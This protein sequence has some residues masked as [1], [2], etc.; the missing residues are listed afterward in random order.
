MEVTSDMSKSMNAEVVIIGGGGSGLVAAISALEKGVKNILILEKRSK[1]GGN[2]VFPSGILAADTP[3]Q[4]RLGM[5]ASKDEV[6]RK[7]M[8]YSHWRINGSL[9]RALIDKSAD[10]LQWL[11]SKGLRFTHIITHYPN[12]FPNTYITT[13]ETGAGQQMVNLLSQ[14]LQKSKAVRILCDTPARK[15]LV[16]KKGQVS[17]VLAETKDGTEIE[18]EAKSV[19]IGTGGFSG[20]EKLIKK[21]DPGYNKLD[22]PP[23]GIPQ[24]G[25][26]IHMATEIG[27]TVDGMVSYEWE[28]SSGTVALTILA[29]RPAT[30]WVNN[31][32]QRFTDESIPILVEAANA[33]YRQPGKVMYCLF[34]KTLKD[35]MLSDVLS[36]FETFSFS[37]EEKTRTSLPFAEKAECDLKSLIAEGKAIAA[38][39]LDKVARFIGAKPDVLKTNIQEYN[40]FCAKGHDE[41]FA[42]P[43]NHLKPLLTPPFY[44]IKCNIKLTTTHGGIK[45]DQKAQALDKNDE[46]IPGLYAAGNETGATDG[47][48]YN[49]WLS[50]HSFAFAVNTGRIAG[51]EAARYISS[52]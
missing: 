17:G 24:D 4:R 16:N 14:E 46:P 10:T 48:S 33:I 52:K 7:A 11:E 40:N 39:S 44:A 2:A 28:H 32:G 36:P 6:F 19:I 3:L 26:G 51:E 35:N 8:E 50:G 20:N 30:L 22:V 47:D 41:I 15:I 23:I 13:S 21:Y 31:K 43:L 34:D 37:S 18:I 25:E 42:K 45:I 9:V 1:L 12:Q 38:G 49:M 27:A 5:D 29:R